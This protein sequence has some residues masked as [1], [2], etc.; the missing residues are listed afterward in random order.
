MRQ[1]VVPNIGLTCSRS[2]QSTL[3]VNV[4][5]VD[6]AY[7]PVGVGNV[8]AAH[9]AKR[10]S[11]VTHAGEAH[12]GKPAL[13]VAILVW[14]VQYACELDPVTRDAENESARTDGHVR[15]PPLKS[16]SGS[17]C[18][19]SSVARLFALVSRARN[20]GRQWGVVAC[21]ARQQ[22]MRWHNIMGDQVRNKVR[23]M[24]IIVWCLGG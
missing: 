19:L 6:V 17:R 9:S 7:C 2:K 13:Q 10:L 20:G 23:A 22:A 12:L 18:L 24:L 3:A 5:Q 1:A 4:P 16:C 11:H 21:Q 14:F 8:R 15:V